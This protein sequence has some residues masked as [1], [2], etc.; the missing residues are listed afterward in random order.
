M[1]VCDVTPSLR[2]QPITAS[3]AWGAAAANSLACTLPTRPTRM[4]PASRLS[5]ASR[6]HIHPVHRAVSH[7]RLGWSS[8]VLEQASRV[9]DY[10][11]RKH[12]AITSFRGSERTE[13]RRLRRYILNTWQRVIPRF[14]KEAV[15]SYMKVVPY[16]P[17]RPELTILKFADLRLKTIE[18]IVWSLD[19]LDVVT[20]GPCL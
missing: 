19:D 8:L 4:A 9:H 15:P 12:V 16:M 17:R 1:V 10:L 5:V 6:S 2:V 13:E 14:L 3:V 7:A 11:E 20:Y 18:A